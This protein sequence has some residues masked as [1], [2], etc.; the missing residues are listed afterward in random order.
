MSLINPNDIESIDVLKDASATAIYGS[1]GANGVIIITTKRGKAGKARI[2]FSANFGISKIS[3]MVEMLDAY[4][5]ANFMNEGTINGG[6]Y[7]NLLYTELPYDGSWKYKRD[8][9]GNVIRESGSYNPIPEDFLH[10]GWRT[11]EYGNRKWVEG[12]D[13]MDEILQTG[14]TQEYNVSVSGGNERSNYAISGNYTT[15]D[16]IIKNSGTSVSRS[17]QM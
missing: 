12:T 14:L 7:D 3:K 8:G 6:L 16:G 9:N 10:P 11:D 5:Y 2:E 15:Q 1:R 17:V 4:T 13:W